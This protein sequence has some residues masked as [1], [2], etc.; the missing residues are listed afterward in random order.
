MS[1]AI[2]ALLSEVT[3]VQA[4]VQAELDRVAQARGSMDG[5]GMDRVDSY[6]PR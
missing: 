2:G 1:M 3:E 4:K 5:G 6:G